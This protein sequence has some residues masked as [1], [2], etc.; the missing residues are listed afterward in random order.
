MAKR[1]EFEIR[2]TETLIA[3]EYLL[4]YTD[5]K[6]PAMAQDICRY[7]RNKYGLKFADDT[8]NTAGDEI[9]R[10][11]VVEE[12]DFLRKVTN[13]DYAD[14]FPFVVSKTSG[15]RGKYYIS[16]NCFTNDELIKIIAAIRNDKYT[17]QLDTENL[18]KTLIHF[19]CNIFNG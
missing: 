5:K 14:S 17:R 8:K 16:K 9:K 11:R 2:L 12:L 10:Q 3:I 13:G 18:T 7:A 6:H 1:K 19:F 4:I 15:E